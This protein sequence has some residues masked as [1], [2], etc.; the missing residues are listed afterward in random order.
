MTE[1]FESSQ[2]TYGDLLSE[3]AK[4]S[5]SFAKLLE[6]DKSDEL[7]EEAAT[8]GRLVTKLFNLAEQSTITSAAQEEMKA[9][10]SRLNT[11]YK[12]LNIT[13]DD[14][15]SKTATTKEALESYLKTL[16]N[17]KQY[18]NAQNQWTSTY[19]LLKQQEAQFEKLKSEAAEPIEKY[20]KALRENDNIPTF[21]EYNEYQDFWNRQIEYTNAAGETVKGTFREAWD[22][23]M[24]NIDDMKAACEG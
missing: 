10:I 7:E 15:I 8:A 18:E 6:E 9:I 12:G 20:N 2:E 3:Q 23:S 14:V 17:Q 24:K 4:I 1:E 11:E 19:A 13:Y 22:E 16:Y 21:W 5:D